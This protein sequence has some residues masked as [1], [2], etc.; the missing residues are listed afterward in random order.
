[1]KIYLMTDMEG[2]A[3]VLNFQDWTSQGN[4]YYEMGREFLTLEVNAAI[5]GFFEAG[6]TEVLVG[7][8]HGGGGINLK[9]LDPRVE[10]MRGW[11]EG[12]WPLMLDESFDAVAVV[13]QH[14]KASTPRAHLAHTQ[15]LAYIDLS[16]NGVS[17]GEFGQLAMCASELGVPTIFGSGDAAFARE[18]KE[19][20]PGIETVA[21]KQG[22]R[23]GTGDELKREEYGRYTSSAI[24]QH[25]E[26][27]R[28]RIRQGAFQALTRA[29]QE[30]FGLIQMEAP[31]ERVAFFRPSE[32]QPNRT[33]SR[34][35]HPS[36]VIGLMNLPFH[37]EP[38]S[39]E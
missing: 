28:R 4:P 20:V 36:S 6:A 16:I 8:G 1:M 25:P 38:V 30:T 21:V 15:S 33:V 24:H 22:L 10:Y 34:E 19:L 12:P 7:D 17:I 5:E 2:V 18:A 14:A 31:F 9:F 13:G 39:E 29:Q 27:A 11:G 3:G 23:V 26:R 32:N 37:P 35:T